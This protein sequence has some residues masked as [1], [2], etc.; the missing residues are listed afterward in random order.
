MRTVRAPAR[1]PYNARDRVDKR[2]KYYR[3]A[4]DLASLGSLN[5]TLLHRQ[6]F[7]RNFCYKERRSVEKLFMDNCDLVGIFINL[8]SSN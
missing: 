2:W 5:V 7:S 3:P 8:P 6:I 1:T 4:I